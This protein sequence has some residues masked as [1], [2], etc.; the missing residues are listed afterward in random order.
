M[1]EIIMSEELSDFRIP[2][3]KQMLAI[4]DLLIENIASTFALQDFIFL[5]LTDMSGE[6]SNEKFSGFIQ[7]QKKEIERYKTEIMTS[8]MSKYAE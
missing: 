8:F 7:N 4:F 1:K 6:H 3:E 2:T 5:K